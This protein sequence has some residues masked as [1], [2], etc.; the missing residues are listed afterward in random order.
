MRLEWTAPRVMVFL[1]SRTE[2]EEAAEC[3]GCPSYHRDIGSIEEKESRLNRWVSGECGSPFLACMTAAGPGVD[4]PL[5]RW[6]AYIEDP[7]GLIDYAQE[8]GRAGRNAEP[9]GATVYMK[10]DPRETAPPTSLDYP[11]PADDRRLK[12]YLRGTECRRLSFARELD[13]SRH[14]SIC[15]PDDTVCDVCEYQ[16]GSSDTEKDGD[17]NREGGREIEGEAEGEPC[18]TMAQ[19]SL[20]QGRWIRHRRQL[21][22]EQHEMGK[23]VRRL[24]LVQGTCV[25][26]RIL[27]P[28]PWWEHPLQ[29][30]RRHHKWEY[31]RCVKAIRQQRSAAGW[32][33]GYAAC[34]FCGQLQDMCQ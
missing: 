10:R 17:R 6:V 4:Y 3:L 11:D 16:M 7:Y 33:P 12:G 24:S 14:C 13:E 25:L 23:Y 22:Q 1:R 32:V 18:A 31:I 8:S 21:M 27:T 34:Y 15:G 5:M 9:A 28:R 26:C 30:C 29:S 20:E 2:A 19:E